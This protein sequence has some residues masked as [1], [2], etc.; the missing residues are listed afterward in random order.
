MQLGVANSLINSRL[1]GASRFQNNALTTQG[2]T[3]SNIN[4]NATDASQAL[5]LG[6]SAQGQT[7]SALGDLQ[8]QEADWKKFG[9]QNLNAAYGAN[10]QEDQYVNQMNQEHFQNDVSLKGAQAANKFAKRKALWNTVGGI[11]NFGA[12]LIGAGAFKGGGGGGSASGGGSG[13]GSSASYPGH[14]I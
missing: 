5:M 4:R 3:L 1:P 7:D 14:T 10:Q 12:S 11:A 8:L 13:L 2:T 6:A 9:L